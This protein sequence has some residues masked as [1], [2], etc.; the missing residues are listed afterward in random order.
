MR[1]QVGSRGEKFEDLPLYLKPDEV[2]EILRITKASFYKRV[3][4]G[5]IPTTKVG[6]SLRVNKFKLFEYLERRTRG[7]EK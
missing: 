5:E 2:C 3:F 1:K 6:A 7:G 4:V